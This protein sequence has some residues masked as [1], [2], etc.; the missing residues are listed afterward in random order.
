MVDQLM[1]GTG[2]CIFKSLAKK[3]ALGFKE[4]HQF[5]SGTILLTYKSVEG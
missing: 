5:Q 3:T 2:T 1:A 4:M